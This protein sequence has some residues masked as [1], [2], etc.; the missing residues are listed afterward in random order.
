MDRREL[1]AS[2]GLSVCLPL[3]GCLGDGS[4]FGSADES[5]DSDDRPT[6]TTDATDD[7]ETETAAP[8]P[9][10]ERFGCSSAYRP[11]SDVEAG[12]EHE[13]EV[14]DETEVY[15]SVGSTDYPTPP[16]AFDGDAVETFVAEY[17]KVYQR[18][19]YLDKHEDR[20]VEF[21]PMV[22]GVERFDFRDPVA[23]VRVDFAVHF[24]AVS[25][26]S[27]VMT[28]P[29]GEA[30]VY[31]VDETGLART[32]AEYRG[33][34]EGSVREATPDPLEDGDLLECF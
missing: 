26:D 6:E 27:V 24:A 32:D 20:L 9:V 17:E 1:L 2:V 28:E 4:G 33:N 19:V 16:A 14:G 21:D 8:N 5:S 10:A 31:A 30:A 23:T 34:V 13:V 25:G 11:E 3:G 29:A 7:D 22:E 18:N 12:V 15:E